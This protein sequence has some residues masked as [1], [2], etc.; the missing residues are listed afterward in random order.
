[1]ESERELLLE[2]YQQYHRVILDQLRV[3]VE[4]QELE[5]VLYTVIDSMAARIGQL[6]VYTPE[7]RLVYIRAIARNTAVS[8]LRRRIRMRKKLVDISDDALAAV[9]DEQTGVEQEIL[10]RDMLSA[11]RGLIGKLPEEK[12]ALLEMKY[13]L[14]MDNRQ[15][16]EMMH[17]SQTAVRQRLSRLRREIYAML[18]AMGYGEE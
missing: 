11:L 4:P 8:Y 10:R 3:Y 1:M 15:I 7:R 12:R 16:A 6:A 17:L 9:A 13:L 14:D 5:D 2:L 18:D